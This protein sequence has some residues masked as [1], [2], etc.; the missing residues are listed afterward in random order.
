M[1]VSGPTICTLEEVINVSRREAR[2][3]KLP[4]SSCPS[5]TAKAAET[6]ISSHYL[7]NWGDRA[8]S[9]PSH[10]ICMFMQ[11][12]FLGQRSNRAY[13]LRCKG[14]IPNLCDCAP[15][16]TRATQF[17]VLAP[18]FLQGL[19]VW[20]DF[21][22]CELQPG[23]RSVMHFVRTICYAQCPHERIRFCQTGI[24]ADTAAAPRLNGVV[25]HP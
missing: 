25:N 4:V 20:L 16:S 22:L 23:N 8:S 7:E 9:R 2:Q 1:E 14:Q 19:L 10:T 12:R 5:K 11:T 21:V 17:S 18:F 3:S 24:V 13:R 15:A 6:L